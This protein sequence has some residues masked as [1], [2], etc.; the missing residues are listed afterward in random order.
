MG[1]SL[2]V[3]LQSVLENGKAKQQHTALRIRIDMAM[4]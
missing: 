3:K 2:G 4:E 1:S